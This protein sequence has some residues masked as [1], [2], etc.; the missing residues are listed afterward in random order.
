MILWPLRFG[1]LLVLSLSKEVYLQFT[2][3]LNLC[4]FNNT[5]FAASEKVGI[6]YTDLTITPVWWLSSLQLTVL[7]RFGNRCVIEVVGGVFWR[8]LWFVGVLV[9]GLSLISSFFSFIK[10]YMTSYSG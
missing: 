1:W 8:F 2:L 10:V 9:K 7:S 3:F 4:P 5:A 6:P